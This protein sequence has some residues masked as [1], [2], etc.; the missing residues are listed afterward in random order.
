MTVSKV[1]GLEGNFAVENGRKFE[2]EEHT[3]LIEELHSEDCLGLLWQL[4]LPG[5]AALP[6]QPATPIIAPHQ[7]LQSDR[8]YPS[9]APPFIYDRLRATKFERSKNQEPNF[10]YMSW[11]DQNPEKG[12]SFLEAPWNFFLPA[13]FKFECK[14]ASV[15]S[16]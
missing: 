4:F 7:Q 8:S 10:A 1:S 2:S 9:Q 5:W 11:A 12:V 15:A 13:L 3:V 6:L 14:L 16:F